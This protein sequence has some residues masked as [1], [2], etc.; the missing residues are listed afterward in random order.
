MAN[1]DQVRV[2]YPEGDWSEDIKG[3]DRE[4][5]ENARGMQRSNTFLYRALAPEVPESYKGRMQKAAEE[6]MRLRR[7]RKKLHDLGEA[8]SAP[9][10]PRRSAKRS[11]KRK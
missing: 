6:G 4:M 11:A 7:S 5:A 3:A 10:P 8:L 1:D 9:L 2:E